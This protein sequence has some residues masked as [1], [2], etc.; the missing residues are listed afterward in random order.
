M[1]PEARREEA[2]G[3]RRGSRRMR[4]AMQREAPSW[5]LSAQS[6]DPDFYKTIWLGFLDC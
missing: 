4:E 2:T 5:S 1:A 6:A 3:F